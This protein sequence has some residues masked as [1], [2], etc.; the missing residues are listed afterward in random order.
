MTAVRCV[1]NN[2]HLNLAKF[3]ATMAVKLCS[4]IVRQTERDGGIE[5]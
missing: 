3:Y 5:P 2:R 4:A 1:V